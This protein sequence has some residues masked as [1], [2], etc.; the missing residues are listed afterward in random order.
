M[1]TK[2]T[3]AA[4]KKTSKKHS[5]HDFYDKLVTAL[6][7]YK[8][9]FGEKFESKLKKASKF[10]AE[11]LAKA[12]K[13]KATPKKKPVKKVIPKKKAAPKKIKAKL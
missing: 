3:P 5:H 8:E 4:A 1:A 13:K 6:S 2:K 12:E 9:A 10:F 11:H 7:D